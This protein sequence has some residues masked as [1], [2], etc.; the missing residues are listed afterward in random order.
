MLRKKCKKTCAQERIDLIHARTPNTTPSIRSLFETRVHQMKFHH[1]C[2]SMVEEHLATRRR[3]VCS[4]PPR[5]S[6][7][8]LHG[9]PMREITAT[10][11]M[12]RRRLETRVNI[13]FPTHTQWRGSVP[14]GGIA[15]CDPG[16][17]AVTRQ[18]LGK[19][20]ARPST[21]RSRDGRVDVSV[22]LACVD[23]TVARAR[24]R[25]DAP[26]QRFPSSTR[27]AP[28]VLTSVVR[29]MMCRR[30]YELEAAVPRAC[31]ASHR[32]WCRRPASRAIARTERSPCTA[33]VSATGAA[34]IDSACAAASHRS[35]RIGCP[36]FDASV[37]A[38]KLLRGQPSTR[39]DH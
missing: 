11:R 28:R 2:V 19:T 25:S 32:A 17:P 9:T 18:C 1:A 31:P 10:L 37:A 24:R 15:Q 34:A 14:S 3:S 5:A 8:R 21:S 39:H 30:A 16:T 22:S 38:G 20:R 27:I 23:Q 4:H 36:S 12:D 6:S 13:G 35:A 26:T 33:G 7:N 29:W